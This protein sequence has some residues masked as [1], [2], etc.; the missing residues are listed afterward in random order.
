[1]ND[2]LIQNFIDRSQIEEFQEL[3]QKISCREER[4][5]CHGGMV[6]ACIAVD[7][8]PSLLVSAVS[9]FSEYHSLLEGNMLPPIDRELKKDW[10]KLRDKTVWTMFEKDMGSIRMK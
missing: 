4:M 3:R 9:P 6:H 1:M 7:D 10:S 5:Y 8:N 2:S